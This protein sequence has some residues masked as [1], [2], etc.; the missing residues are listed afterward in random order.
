MANPWFLSKSAR[1]PVTVKKSATKSPVKVKSKVTTADKEKPK[2]MTVTKLLMKTVRRVRDV[3]N[4]VIVK[5]LDRAKTRSGLPGFKAIVR[6]FPA[7]NLKHPPRRC[8]VVALDGARRISESKQ[9]Q[10]Y[11]ECED[12]LYTWEVALAEVGAAK[13]K[14]SNGEFPEVRNPQMVPGVCKH[15]FVVLKTI[16]QRAM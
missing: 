10:V 12:F 13:V 16:K 8:S 6:A 14:N 1:S 2:G 11:C 9:V 7:D 3:A 15:L 5:S 4:T